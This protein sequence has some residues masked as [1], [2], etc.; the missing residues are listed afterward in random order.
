MLRLVKN[1]GYD[2]YIKYPYYSKEDLE[3]RALEILCEYNYELLKIPQPIP[4]ENIIENHYN[5]ILDY[6]NLS[7][8]V[9][10][11]A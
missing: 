7:W 1:E 2:D 5:L 6:Q 11:W 4:I 10:S 8:M 9:I 3:K